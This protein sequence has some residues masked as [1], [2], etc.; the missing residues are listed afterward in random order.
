MKRKHIIVLI[1]LVLVG[2]IIFKLSSNKRSLEEKKKPEKDT[3]V[4][5]PVKDGHCSGRTAD[6]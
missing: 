1:V 2:L 5:I 6:D 3:L 4:R